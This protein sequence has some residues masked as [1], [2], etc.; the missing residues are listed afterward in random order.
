MGGIGA[1]AGAA[2]AAL[3]RCCQKPGVQGGVDHGLSG[4]GVQGAGDPGAAGVFGGV[5]QGAGVERGQDV[6]VGGE[7]W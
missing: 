5:A 7:G 4:G 1:V 6:G 2:A 3:G